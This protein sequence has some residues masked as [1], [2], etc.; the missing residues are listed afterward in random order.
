MLGGDR[1]RVPNTLWVSYSITQPFLL[2][3]LYSEVNI[4]ISQVSVL[5]SWVEECAT[6]QAFQAEAQAQAPSFLGTVDNS[7]THDVGASD[8]H[9]GCSNVITRTVGN[10]TTPYHGSLG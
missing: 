5:Q 3:L 8:G 7:G 1:A 2:Y 6:T 9:L 4:E 10:C